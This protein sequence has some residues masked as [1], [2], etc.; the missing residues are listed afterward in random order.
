MPRDQGGHQ[1][2][3]SQPSGLSLARSSAAQGCLTQDLAGDCSGDV[4]SPACQ[5]ALARNSLAKGHR[6]VESGCPG[7]GAPAGSMGKESPALKM[8]L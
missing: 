4:K 2:G 3:H 5:P 8:G 7:R 6:A 1:A